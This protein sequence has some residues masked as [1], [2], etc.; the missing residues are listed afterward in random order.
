LQEPYLFHGTV[1]ANIAYSR[2]DAPADEIIEAARAANAHE[3]IVRLPD[4]YDTVIGERGQTL[5]GGERQRISI[6]RAV[7]RN[8]R[9]LILDEATASVD[10][11]TEV[12]IQ[13]ALERLV[14]NRTTFAIAHRLSTL[15]K[16]NRLFV[17]DRGK[18]AEMGTHAELLE[19]GGLYSRLCKLQSELSK[20]QAW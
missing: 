14:Q 16:A 8:P 5:S 3:F 9:I 4:G 20:M 1:W 19:S 15:R 6:A 7:L 13:S 17:L 11:E 2:P 18:M 10:T 12:L